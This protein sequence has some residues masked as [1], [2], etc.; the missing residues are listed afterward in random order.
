MLYQGAPFECRK[1]YREKQ[2]KITNWEIIKK[3]LAFKLKKEGFMCVR[4]KL[5]TE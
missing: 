3:L 4:Y 5:E 2:Q 1:I